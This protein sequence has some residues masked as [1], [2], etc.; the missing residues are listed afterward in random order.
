MKRKFVYIGAGI[1]ILGYLII[2][3]ITLPPLVK[4]ARLVE[5]PENATAYQVAKILKE[6]GIIKSIAW[7]LF[8]TNRYRVQN[9]LKAGV[10]EFSGRTPLKKVISKI[11]RGDVILVKVT[12]PEGS[13]I[14]DVAEILR[15]K[16]L[17]SDENKFIEYAKKKKMEGF[18][19]PDTYFFPHNVSIEGITATMWVRFKEV[20]KELTGE[21]VNEENFDKVKRIITIA[22]IVEKE[23]IYPKERKII[24]GIIL[25]RLRKNLP[26]Q[27]CA[28]VEYALGCHKARLTEKDLKIKSPYNTYLYRGLPPTPICNPGKISIK[29]A[30]NP[31][32]TDYLYFLSMGNGRN[33]FS[34]TYKQHIRAKKLYFS[35]DEK[36]KKD[37]G[38]SQ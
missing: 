26:I 23:A 11:V 31:E 35:P 16:G 3:L 17:I 36:S 5:I 37:T 8:L 14:K 10:Y 15:K 12:I 20:Y 9:K 25:N 27:S 33:Y 6:K 32:N 38:F 19:F 24:A 29:A 2:K 18:L 4:P 34:K 21:E 1:L 22:S 13:T 7:F 28:T 30:L